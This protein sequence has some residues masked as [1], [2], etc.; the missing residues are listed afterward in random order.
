[1]IK[2]RA[3]NSV[4]ELF[5]FVDTGTKGGSKRELGRGL[6]ILLF[7]ASCDSGV[8]V[9]HFRSNHGHPI[10]ECLSPDKIALIF[11]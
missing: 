6:A 8:N 11:R 5:F 9:S 7:P 2:T 10:P 3:H 4:M 1:M